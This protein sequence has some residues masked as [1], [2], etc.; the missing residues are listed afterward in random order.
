MQV[1]TQIILVQMQYMISQVW[2]EDLTH[3]KKSI[4]RY[5]TYDFINKPLNPTIYPDSKDLCVKM[6]LNHPDL[7][8][9]LCP[10]RHLKEYQNLPS[11]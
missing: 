6:G 5:C 2:S 3:L 10:V 4:A 9:L 1:F 8:L 7:T 11:E